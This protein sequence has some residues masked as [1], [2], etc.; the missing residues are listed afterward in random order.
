MALAMSAEVIITRCPGIAATSP[1]RCAVRQRISS[2]RARNSQ[3][4]G[5]PS[6]LSLL[7]G[8]SYRKSH[9]QQL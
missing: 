8:G 9:D 5:L 1:F 2:I 6:G 3:S 7:M 4:P